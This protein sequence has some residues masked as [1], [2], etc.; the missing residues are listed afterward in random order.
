[1]DGSVG[2]A[3]RSRVGALVRR[4]ISP[5]PRP[6]GA[7]PR[8]RVGIGGDAA[9]G[10]DERRRPA[11]PRRRRRAARACPP[12]APTPGMRKI[13]RGISSRRRAKCRGSVAPTTAPIP[14]RP[15]LARQPPGELVDERRRGARAAAPRAPAGPAG[16]RRRDCWCGRGRRSPPR[17]PRRR[18]PAARARRAP[19]SGLA[20]KASAPRPG[21]RP[22]GGRRLADQGLR[23][24]GGGDR[25]V[26]ALAVGDDQQARLAGGG[27]DRLPAPPSRARRG[28]RSR[29]AAA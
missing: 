1:M 3:D 5:R 10:G 25:D 17:P 2:A 19:S 7:R 4:S 22:P 8:R 13:A 21:D 11:R 15:A 20:V 28:A 14:L 12:W 24:G 18:R 29:R 23:V 26:A 16:R 27:A 9:R 6:A